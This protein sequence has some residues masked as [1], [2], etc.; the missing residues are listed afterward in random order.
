MA[1]G[2]SSG[3]GGQG[4]APLNYFDR[5]KIRAATKHLHSRYASVR[6][7]AHNEIARLLKRR[8]QSRIA[9]LHPKKLARQAWQR[10]N[11]G[12]LHKCGSC[13]HAERD[14]AMFRQHL[15]GHMREAGRSRSPA[16]TP[17]MQQRQGP[18]KAPPRAPARAPDMRRQAGLLPQNQKRQPAR[19]A[20]SAFPGVRFAPARTAPLPH[21]TVRTPS[22]SPDKPRWAGLRRRRA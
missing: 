5:L 11:Y 17:G 6:N 20:H 21:E 14:K 19:A 18:A 12:K 3:N 8:Q 9:R 1:R 13:G 15:N 4:Y 16:A 7:A 2:K 22:R 10:A